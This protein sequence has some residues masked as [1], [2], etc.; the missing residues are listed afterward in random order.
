MLIKSLKYKNFRQFKGENAIEF[1]IDPYKNVTII[2]GDNTYGK[3]TLLQMFNWCFY[4]KAL[5]ND[6]PDFLLNLELASNMYNG[7]S[8]VEVMVEIL[9]S[10]EGRDYII[11]RKQEY[12]KTNGKVLHRP[13]KLKVNY[14]HY[15]ITFYFKISSLFR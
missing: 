3:T 7:D 14:N 15:P 12:F 10:H 8:P 13:S 5:F 9:L 4:N 11:S 6:N 2:L 1:S